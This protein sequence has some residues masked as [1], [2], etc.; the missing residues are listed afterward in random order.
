[1]N[2]LWTLRTEFV[3]L[4][5]MAYFMVAIWRIKYINV[6]KFKW[7]FSLAF[8]HVLLD[9]ITVITVNHMD[10]VP[11]TLNNIVHILFYLSGLAYVMMVFS[12]MA[13]LTL[14][15]K[16]YKRWML[17]LKIIFLLYLLSVPFL[18]IEYVQ[19]N[20]T[21]YSYGSCVFALYGTILVMSAICALFLLVNIRRL[22]SRVV[23]TL[24]PVYIVFFVLITVQALIPELLFTGAATTILTMA[25]F[26][27]LENPIRVYM[28]LAYNDR[29]TELKNRPCFDEDFS[30]YAN[31]LTVMSEK[32]IS[33]SMVVCDVNNLKSVNDTYGHTAGDMLIRVAAAILS[34]ELQ[35][36]KEVYRTGGD[37]FT[38]FYIDVPKS[39]IEDELKK[40]RER[41][42]AEEKNYEFPLKIAV[43]VAYNKDEPLA[44]TLKRADAEMYKN[45]A[46]MKECE[47]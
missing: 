34:Q 44:E 23:R 47:S 45:K 33:V 31:R 39:N 25:M 21:M 14:S 18:N 2:V 9:M 40:V 46:A 19:G 10:V 41:C 37:E 24:L 35:S 5:I 16:K 13:E 6:V 11:L 17:A 43:G 15:H 28:E 3:C 38:A 42:A 12:Y 36:A 4:G 1:M 30:K 26:F 8:A 22:D 29:L 32:Q 27:T 7:V 20:G